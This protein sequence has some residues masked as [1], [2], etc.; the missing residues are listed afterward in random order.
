MLSTGG[1]KGLD[2]WCFHG[3]CCQSWRVW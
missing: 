3:W 2:N 1:R